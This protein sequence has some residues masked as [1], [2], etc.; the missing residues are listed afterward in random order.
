MFIQLEG[1]MW[2]WLRL[3]ST[4]VAEVWVWTEYHSQWGSL[5]RVW[6]VNQSLVVEHNMN[7]W[8]HQYW[9]VLPDG[10]DPPQ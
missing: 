4:H 5:W 10:E 6:H 3:Y 9:A 7:N 1:P 8:Y 2:V